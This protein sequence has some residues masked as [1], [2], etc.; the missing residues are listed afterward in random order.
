MLIVGGGPAGSTCAWALRAG[1]PRRR[2]HG[3]RD[4]SARQG[5]R[6]VDHAA[7]RRRICG[8]TFDDY[9]HGRT[10]QPITGFRIGLI[11][12][13]GDV[14]ATYDRPVSFGIRRCEFD[15]YLL[16]RSGARLR[17]GTPDLRAS[18]ATGRRWIVNECLESPDARRRRRPLLPGRANAQRGRPADRRWS[19]RKRPSSRSMRLNLVVHDVARAARALLFAA[20]STATA[21][22]SA[23]RTTSTSGSGSID[24]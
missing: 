12:V 15:H 10:F 13:G 23:S 19:S 20:R 24:L 1:G 11:G 5:V 2:R 18:A 4:L 6:R 14:D 9:R 22:A 16:R 8:L 3:P 21:G 17:L 7:G